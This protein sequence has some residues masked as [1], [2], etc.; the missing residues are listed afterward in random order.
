M[1]DKIQGF[2]FNINCIVDPE[3]QELFYKRAKAKYNVDMELEY[4]TPL[5]SVGP[6]KADSLSSRIDDSI[7]EV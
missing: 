2:S 1:M 6:E 5:L 4:I 3:L 7:M